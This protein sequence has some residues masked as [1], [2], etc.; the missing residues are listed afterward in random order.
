[1]RLLRGSS[2]DIFIGDINSSAT[3]QQRASFGGFTQSYVEARCIAQEFLD[4]P[5]TTSATTYKL[6]ML[7]TGGNTSY[8]NAS[9][10]TGT[11][12]L[13]EVSA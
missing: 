7:N 3:S 13:M 6:Q 2:D 8:F 9:T 5:N 11:L 10:H 1:M 4:S 12:T